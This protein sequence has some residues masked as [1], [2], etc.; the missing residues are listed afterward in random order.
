MPRKAPIH[1]GDVDA[2]FCGDFMSR[3]HV[4]SLSGMV[5]AL[6]GVATMDATISIMTKNHVDHLDGA[7]LH[8]GHVY[9]G[10]FFGLPDDD[11]LCLMLYAC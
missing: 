9:R 3:G 2:L 7:V 11:H 1:I 4:M 10:F 8:G 5:N 6:D